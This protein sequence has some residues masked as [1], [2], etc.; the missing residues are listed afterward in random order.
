M[1]ITFPFDVAFSSTKHN[2]YTPHI[3]SSLFKVITN[4]FTF[5]FSNSFKNQ[6]GKDFFPGAAFFSDVYRGTF[7]LGYWMLRGHSQITSR[8]KKRLFR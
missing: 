6:K 8:K 5:T 1:L 4:D 2:N 3:P 7:S